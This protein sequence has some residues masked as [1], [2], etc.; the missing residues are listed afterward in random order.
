MLCDVCGKNT[1]TV[2][3]TE[4]IDEQMNEL[5]L[6]EECARQKST[7]MES[8]F[9]L[10]DL[11]AGLAD[12]EK[13]AKK[14]ETVSLKCENCGLTYN[15][16]KKIGRLG[17]GECYSAFKK[18]LVPLLKKIHGSGQ[19]L[20]TSPVR[21]TKILRK[22]IDLTTLRNNLKKAIE[23]EAFEEAA[24]IRDQIKELE[25]KHS[26]NDDEVKKDEA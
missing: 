26:Q 4:I 3:L 24:K 22:K 14:L 21:G 15:E 6:C 5:H 7:Q 1:A 10:S 9:G 13:P 2:H 19:H 8:Q 18:Y 16:F 12:F 25:N 23:T 11:L 20:G 17:C